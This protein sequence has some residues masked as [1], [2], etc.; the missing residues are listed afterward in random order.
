[1]AECLQCGETFDPDHGNQKYCCSLCFELHRKEYKRKHARNY[2]QKKVKKEREKKPVICDYCKTPLDIE[3]HGNK[4]Y[5]DDCRLKHRAKY[6]ENWAFDRGYRSDGLLTAWQVYKREVWS[7]CWDC[8]S[9]SFKRISKHIDFDEGVLYH[10]RVW[11]C[12]NC[13]RRIKIRKKSTRKEGRVWVA[14]KKHHFFLYYYSTN[15]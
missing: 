15:T 9:Q 8:G 1:M 5:H 3:E 10:T 2:Y 6:L 12:S 4:K 14:P 13:G 11:E 7:T